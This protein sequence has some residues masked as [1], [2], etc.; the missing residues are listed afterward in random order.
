MTEKNRNV[1][2]L[3]RVIR[4]L[5]KPKR[6]PAGFGHRP[7]ARASPFEP[8]MTWRSWKNDKENENGLDGI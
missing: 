1:D 7:N 5:R 2:R 6:D 8:V 4:N 3:H